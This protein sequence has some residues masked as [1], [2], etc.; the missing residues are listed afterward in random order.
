MTGGTGGNGGTG[1][2][3]GVGGNGGLAGNGGKGGAGASLG[4]AIYSVGT[5]DLIDCTFTSNDAYAGNGGF[6]GA[7]VTAALVVAGAREASG[8]PVRP[9]EPEGNAGAAEPGGTPGSAGVGGSAEGGAVYSTGTL[10]V[11]GTTNFDEDAVG[12]AQVG[13]EVPVDLAAKEESGGT[14]ALA[15]RVPPGPAPRMAQAAMAVPAGAGV[16][17]VRPARPRQVSMP[18]R[19]ALAAWEL[20]VPS[21]S[22]EPPRSGRHLQW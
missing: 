4:G 6:G 19:V 12:P 7:P 16:R 11:S 18:N 17:R 20:A 2:S 14:A 1:A 8:R 22:R 5:V 15:A 13:A 10:K 9:E 3:G 21:L